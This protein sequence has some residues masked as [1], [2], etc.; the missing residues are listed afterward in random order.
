MWEL[1]SE[2]IPNA[3]QKL[4]G[5]IEEVDLRDGQ[6]DGKMR[7]VETHCGNCQRPMHKRHQRCLY[8]GHEMN[9]ENVFQ[10]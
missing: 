4:M 9:R 10:Q 2:S 7:R 3:E 5:K 6:K 8:C 1:L